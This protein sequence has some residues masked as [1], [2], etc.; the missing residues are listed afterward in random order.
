MIFVLNAMLFCLHSSNGAVE[1]NPKALRAVNSRAL[2]VGENDEYSYDAEAAY[3][4]YYYGDETG[5][6]KEG[7]YN[8][9]DDEVAG[10]AV[11]YYYY[12]ETE[13][14]PSA[15]YADD[16]EFDEEDGYYTYYYDDES[17]T[18]DDKPYSFDGDDRFGVGSYADPAEYADYSLDGGESSAFERSSDATCPNTCVAV[19]NSRK[20]T[21]DLWVL[22]G[23]GC[24]DLE[25]YYGCDCTGCGRCQMSAATTAS[26]SSSS[27]SGKSG[28]DSRQG[29]GGGLLSDPAVLLSLAAVALVVVGVGGLIA[30]GLG[31]QAE[32]EAVSALRMGRDAKHRRAVRRSSE[33]G[34]GPESHSG[35][36]DDDADDDVGDLEMRPFVSNE[37]EGNGWQEGDEDEDAFTDAGPQVSS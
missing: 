1:T 21:C 25:L 31:R 26:S 36:G 34:E 3:Y 9:Y 6:S 4:Y 22:E 32:S 11:Y 37:D 17:S 23:Y 12:D 29:S 2:S 28:S 14:G 15:G 5:D 18:Y 10:D 33:A 24:A 27:G 13:K 20:G 8:Y 7:Y 35:G 30:W 16:E 19:E